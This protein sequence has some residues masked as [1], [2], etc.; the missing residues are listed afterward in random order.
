MRKPYSRRALLREV[1]ASATL[2]SLG[3]LGAC[4]VLNDGPAPRPGQELIASNP[5]NTMPWN[6][7]PT[8]RNIDRLAPTRTIA[9]GPSALPLPVHSVNLA[10]LRYTH[11]QQT[12][13]VDEYMRRNRTTGLLVLKGG[14]IALER[15]DMG[16]TAETRWTS[17]SVAKSVTSTLVGAALKDGSIASLDERV[18]KYVPQLKGSA[19]EDCCIEHLLNMTSGVRWEEDYS[20]FRESDIVRFERAIASQRSGAVMEL[21]RTRPRAG[22][23]GSV[24]NYSTG[25]TY[26]LGAIVAAATSTTLSDYLS[27]K[28]WARLGMERDGYWLLDA[29]NGLET[30]GDNFSATLR[31]YA[32]FG[33][34]FLREGVI[35][36]DE[37]LPAGWR[38]YA[39]RPHG[40]VN[41]YGRVD[42]DD[43]DDPLGY[44]YQWWSFPTGAE[45]LPFHDGA[46]TAE[47][48]FGQFI[49]INP[50]QDIVAVVWSA[51]RS[52]WD[53]REERETYSMIGAA[54]AMLR[55]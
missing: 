31:D 49:Y 16:N 22:A 45:A 37:V 15:Y 32:R 19:F 4:T 27:S 53:D 8:F 1:G 18:V 5:L 48:I 34:F 30:G 17:F 50:K 52:P 14:A 26:V 54:T 33:L 11:E 25:D 41:G 43:P 47:G 24:F 13:T 29:P 23:P 2:G 35:G 44:G 42:P 3:L 7:A 38:D 36:D 12:Y 55:S 51:W 21:L 20:I 28:I 10:S 9:R 46:F 40:A 39:T 6:Q